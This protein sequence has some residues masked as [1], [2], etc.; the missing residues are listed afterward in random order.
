MHDNDD[1]HKYNLKTISQ[2]ADDVD[3]D[4]ETD[5][6]VDDDDDDDVVLRS[7]YYPLNFD[8]DKAVEWFRQFDDVVVVLPTRSA[9][10]DESTRSSYIESMGSW[11]TPGPSCRT[12][13]DR[14]SWKF[15][16]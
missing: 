5:D 16:I 15:G 9:S 6:C 13:T 12:T 11:L 10:I 8:Y 14:F 2:W 4:F 7:T 1:T 3:D